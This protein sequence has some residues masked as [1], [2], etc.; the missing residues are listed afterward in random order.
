MSQEIS[1]EHSLKSQISQQ[2][3]EFWKLYHMKQIR[4]PTV[5]LDFYMALLSFLTNYF[6]T[7]FLLPEQQYG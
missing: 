2:G 4:F 3:Q 1:Y 6:H 5:P 7:L